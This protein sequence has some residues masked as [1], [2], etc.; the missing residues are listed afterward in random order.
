MKHLDTFEQLFERRNIGT[1]YHFTSLVNTFHIVTNN[2][3]ESYREI[4]KEIT[5]IYKKSPEN[6]TTFSFTRD[7]NLVKKVG[8]GQI[9]TLLTCRLDFDGSKLSDKYVIRPYNWQGDWEKKQL[10]NKKDGKEYLPTTKL[11]S[12]SEQALITN[13]NHLKDIDKYLENMIV[14]SLED[15]KEE[16]E[17]YADSDPSFFYRLESIVHLAGHEEFYE[18]EIEYDDTT[19]MDTYN[20]IIEELNNSY[21]PYKVGQVS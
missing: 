14:P 17:F 20:Y 7:K 19:I 21:I 2:E 13:D 16:F 11:S 6:G 1:I 18:Y 10:Q 8:Q 5:K 12:E 3:M 15:F 9:D 4:D